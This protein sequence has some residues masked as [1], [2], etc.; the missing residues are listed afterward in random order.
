[1]LIWKAGFVAINHEIFPT[2]RLSVNSKDEKMSVD[3]WT[4]VK[5]N[6]SH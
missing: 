1:M 6:L 5:L 4:Q 3:R 2:A